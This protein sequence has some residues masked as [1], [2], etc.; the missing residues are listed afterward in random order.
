MPNESRVKGAR[1]LDVL[2]QKTDK[3]YYEF[4]R[5]CGISETAYW[6]LYALE[7]S[8]GSATQA[9]IAGEFSYSKQ[10]VHSA[11]KTLEAKGLV[12]LVGVSKDRRGKLVSLTAAGR[13]FSDERI[14]PAIEAEDRAFA[15]LEPEERSEFL[16]LAAAYT[17]AIDRELSVLVGASD[18]TP[19]D[20]SRA[21]STERREH[22]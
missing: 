7:V 19:G 8:G 22:K 13:A 3:I 12:T 4:A 11:L 16:R 9:R 10:T 2:Y 5:G 18:S 1:E 6:I 17:A 14:V 21:A 15:S 20:A